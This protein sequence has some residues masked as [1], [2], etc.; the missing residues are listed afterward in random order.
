MRFLGLSARSPRRKT[1]LA[2]R[3][4][5]PFGRG[6]SSRKLRAETLEHRCLLAVTLACSGPGSALS[7]TEGTFG[8]TPTVVISKPTPDASTLEV[9]LGAGCTFANPPHSIRVRQDFRAVNPSRCILSAWFFTRLEACSP[10]REILSHP[11]LAG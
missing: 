5:H 8:A 6:G 11:R 2:S 9:D 3:K 4:K 10:C 7:L 1:P